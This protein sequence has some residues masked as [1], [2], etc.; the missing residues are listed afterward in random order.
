[1]KIEFNQWKVGETS[2]SLP[3]VKRRR[4]RSNSD[5]T[6]LHHSNH[7]NGSK[8]QQQHPPP[9][10]VEEPLAFA[11]NFVQPLV[12]KD[13]DEHDKNSSSRPLTKRAKKETLETT[14]T[15]TTTKLSLADVYP[16][17]LITSPNC[18]VGMGK[19]S[20]ISSKSKSSLVQSSVVQYPSFP[21]ESFVV[22][23]K[24]EKNGTKV[25][26]FQDADS[27]AAAAAAGGNNLVA[28]V[29]DVDQ[30]RVVGF[31]RR[32][33]R[34]LSWRY[35][36][37]V[38]IVVGTDLRSPAVSLATV[39]SHSTDTLI[40]YGSCQDGSIYFAR[41]QEDEGRGSS[42]FIVEYLEQPFKTALTPIATIAQR[43]PAIESTPP[44]ARA[45]KDHS[46]KKITAGRKRKAGNE[47]PDDVRS[48]STTH[49]TSTGLAFY[50]LCVRK[51]EFV[52]VRHERK[53]W[54]LKLN[55]NSPL[56]E[57]GNSVT[58]PLA[59]HLSQPFFGGSIQDA[60]QVGWIDE[61]SADAT[62]AISFNILMDGAEGREK[63]RRPFLACIS[64]ATATIRLFEVDST[65][66]QFCL[67]GPHFVTALTFDDFLLVYDRAR[68]VLV[69]RKSLAELEFGNYANQWLLCGDSKSCRI[70]LLFV[71]EDKL[72]A[73]MASI[74]SASDFDKQRGMTLAVALAQAESTGIKGCSSLVPRLD[75]NVVSTKSALPLRKY[76]QVDS[77]NH[78]DNGHI[79]R[80]F[81]ISNTDEIAGRSKAL[82]GSSSREAVEILE[83]ALADLKHGSANS[84]EPS[85]LVIMFEKA[86]SKLLK[87]KSSERISSLDKRKTKSAKEC[88]HSTGKEKRATKVNGVKASA[89]QSLRNGLAT[90]NGLKE[91]IVSVSPESDGF[92]S[93]R[94]DANIKAL[95]HTTTASSISLQSLPRDFVNAA[96]VILVG[97]LHFLNT[98]KDAPA[99]KDA[100]I[101]L[102]RLL[103]TGLVS[104]SSHFEPFNETIFALESAGDDDRFGYT[105]IN[106][107]FDLYR[108]CDDVSERQSVA[109]LHYLL[110]RAP[111]RDIAAFFG[112][113]KNKFHHSAVKLAEKFQ[114]LSD[115]SAKSKIVAAKLILTAA[116]KLLLAVTRYS[117]C[118]ETLLRDAIECSIPYQERVL[119]AKLLTESLGNSHLPPA[120]RRR[121]MIILCAVSHCIHRLLSQSD[122]EGLTHIRQSVKREI[123]ITEKLLSLQKHMHSSL[124]SKAPPRVKARQVVDRDAV[125][126]LP[127]YRIERLC[128]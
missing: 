58:I 108:F 106:F 1:M 125:A 94:R 48:A 3:V 23:T 116:R 113:K 55:G 119:V 75:L 39:S 123:L 13:D 27:V 8:Q 28:A 73:A 57:K 46:S 126:G 68:G 2:L 18:I 91:S 80:K 37:G 26:P 14:R 92:P 24:I 42:K 51:D 60:R 87:R 17:V 96:V 112:E 85:F 59:D 105:S 109:C 34:L 12:R 95:H 43:L 7:Q 99:Y 16:D 6:W 122:E 120:S 41:L 90:K 64:L 111:P 74:D 25:P 9:S 84:M 100:R 115:N 45:T 66:R 93:P 33:Q 128:F 50:Q 127:S 70:A 15:T 114:K 110:S 71:K 30:E 47:A 79:V 49:Q 118:N 36:E 98:R 88:E 117:N 61:H 29:L 31:Y 53:L 67:A 78:I 97:I 86:I 107:I 69:H 11:A 63:K 83:S 54:P 22:C 101:L 102:L 124:N 65:V 77:V 56:N 103:R 72:F 10:S 104:A 89:H 82:C 52:L 32:N 5:A 4:K 76:G 19:K 40:A 38:D 35:N 21:G 121:Q 62:L 81:H 44:E 20:G